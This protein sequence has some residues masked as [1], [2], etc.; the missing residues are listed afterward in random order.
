[1]TV[2]NILIESSN[3]IKESNDSEINDSSNE[4]KQKSINNIITPS[5]SDSD[6]SPS[7]E[8]SNENT[9]NDK[10]ENENQKNND[11][12]NEND[13]EIND[14]NN[15]NNNDNANETELEQEIIPDRI[16]VGNLPYE[17]TEDDVRNLTPDVEVV[18]VEIPRKNFF[19]RATNEFIL[20]SKGYGFITYT[21]PND[22]KNAIDSIVGKEISGREIYAKYALPQSKNKFKFLNSNNNNNININ[23]NN[24]LNISN[25][26]YLNLNNNYKKQPYYINNNNFPPHFIRNVQPPAFF[27]PPIPLPQHNHHHSMQL[28]SSQNISQDQKVTSSQKS[29]LQPFKPNPQSFFNKLDNKNLTPFHPTPVQIPQQNINFSKSKEEKQKRLDKG[30]PS[31]DTIF[32]GNLERNVTVDELRNFMKDL[33]PQSIKIPRKTLPNDVYRML[34]S[35][36]VQ[37]QN[38]GIAFVKFENQEIQKKAINLFNGKHWNGKKLNVTVAINSTNDENNDNIEFNNNDVHDDDDDDEPKIT[39]DN[40]NDGDND[41]DNTEI[42]NATE[43]D[44]EEDDVEI[45]VVVSNETNSAEHK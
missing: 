3:D 45:E 12:E 18:S 42:N 14:D 44:E 20:Q 23:N 4:L 33:N 6:N 26:H 30:T 17:V 13:N 38:K 43:A 27:Y 37:I 21:N 7:I 16:F 9:T 39:D 11:N 36:G 41:N 25:N 34:K 28:S 8:I 1:M 19:N 22:A 32:V 29:N 31:I 15:D 40:N 24:N 5:K 35:N 10:T 2:E